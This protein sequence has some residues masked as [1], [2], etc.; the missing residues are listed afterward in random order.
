MLQT[1]LRVLLLGGIDK[2][3]RYLLG[4][5]RSPSFT[6]GFLVLYAKKIK[7][8]NGK[9]KMSLLLGTARLDDQYP[10][11]SLRMENEFIRQQIIDAQ[12]VG[13]VHKKRK[14]VCFE[15]AMSP[16]YLLIAYACMYGMNWTPRWFVDSII[17]EPDEDENPIPVSCPTLH[18]YIEIRDLKTDNGDV[19]CAFPSSV[20]DVKETVIMGI[21]QTRAMTGIEIWPQVPKMF[22]WNT[23]GRLARSLHR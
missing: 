7:Q 23:L 9:E 18:S 20:M 2:R 1:F 16:Q 17:L 21:V 10:E 3:A 5:G 11:E 4:S 6:E 22:A 12:L 8:K 19:I 13:L 15:I 14:R